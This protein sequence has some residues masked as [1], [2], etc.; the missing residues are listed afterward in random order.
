MAF[1]ETKL[2]SLI[3]VYYAEELGE[4]YL[5]GAKEDKIG[6]MHQTSLVSDTNWKER[7]TWE[8]EFYTIPP[9][10]ES[11]PPEAGEF[12]PQ[13]AAINEQT[14][15]SNV[16]NDFKYGLRLSLVIDN[17]VLQPEEVTALADVDVA[18]Y[19]LAGSLI[20]HLDNWS[21]HNIVP[22]RNFMTKRGHNRGHS[23]NDV[24]LLQNFADLYIDNAVPGANLSEWINSPHTPKSHLTLD[25]T[26]YLFPILEKTVSLEELNELPIATLK[27]PKLKDILMNFPVH[28]DTQL[29][30]LN[31]QPL[32]DDAPT[33][34]NIENLD[35]AKVARHLYCE[36]MKSDKAKVLFEEAV[37]LTNLFAMMTI[38][39]NSLMDRKIESWN[40]K[41]LF[42][43]VKKML[44]NAVCLLIN[45]K[46]KEKE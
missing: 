42:S 3:R 8:N 44:N 37:N 13:T 39:S 14:P 7:K 25:R 28:M 10:L 27:N 24:A 32:Q 22:G 12:I 6:G 45:Q 4:N 26:S 15:I 9:V 19:N 18:L 43:V 46:E 16:F 34:G 38:Y 29:K 33:F 41:E 17:N 36:I 30:N 23:A 2:I 35:G 20:T 5:W 40:K 31:L 11:I 1:I 21:G